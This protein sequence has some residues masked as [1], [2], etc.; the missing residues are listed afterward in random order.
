MKNQDTHKTLVLA[1]LNWGLGHAT[2]VVPLIHRYLKENWEVILVA[3]G[4]AYTFLHQEFPDLVCYQSSAKE[5]RYA[6]K[7]SLWAHLFQLVPDFNSLWAHLF[8]L[9]PDFLRNLRKDRKFVRELSQKHTIDLIISDNRY[10]FYHPNIESVIITHQVQL[11]DVGGLSFWKRLAQKQIHRWL[12]RFDACWIVDDAN[13]AYAGQLSRT[14]GLKIP[15][16]YLGLQS[17]M[18]PEKIEQDVDVLIVISGL[19]PQRSLFEKA[20]VHQFKD[21]PKSVVLIGGTNQANEGNYGNI[22]YQQFANTQEL[23]RWMNRSKLVIA[24]SGY[25]TIMD[26]IQLN[27]KAILIP[28]PGQPEQVYLAKWHQNN[29][30]FQVLDAP[31][32]IHF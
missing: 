7:N 30:L 26:L 8:K 3:E 4:V 14:E 5:L 16:Q 21:S 13:N 28:T 15:H 19:E 29:P 10:G 25:S 31:E 24:R 27:K 23:N 18:K 20:L 1:P 11:P 2:R 12:N 9:V 6:S 22:Q 17:R 32:E